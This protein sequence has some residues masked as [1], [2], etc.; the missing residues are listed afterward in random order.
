MNNRSHDIKRNLK[1]FEKK[2]AYFFI[3]YNFN[4][5]SI[6]NQ[7]RNVTQKYPFCIISNYFKLC[8]T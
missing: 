2:F 3:I 1:F 7:K 8:C 4:I 5:T 6:E